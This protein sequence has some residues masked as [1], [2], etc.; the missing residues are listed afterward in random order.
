MAAVAL[1]CFCEMQGEAPTEGE[2][3][4]M[5]LEFSE[6]L[7]PLKPDAGEVTAAFEIMAEDFKYRVGNYNPFQD[8]FKNDLATCIRRA[9][10]KAQTD[11]TSDRRARYDTAAVRASQ[12]ALVE[13]MAAKPPPVEDCPLGAAIKGELKLQ[14]SRN[15]F[16]TW[17]KPASFVCDDGILIVTGSNDLARDWLDSHLRRIIERAAVGVL[18]EQVEVRFEVSE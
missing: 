2:R 14:A 4:N 17:I 10:G 12:A 9:R 8:S 6:T 11:G 3:R 1:A 13:R 16:E 18:D 7:K 15:V 5:L